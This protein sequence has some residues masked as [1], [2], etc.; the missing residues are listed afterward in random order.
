MVEALSTSLMV[1][2][3]EPCTQFVDQPTGVDA[4]LVGKNM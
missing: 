3:V 1:L 2:G 4:L